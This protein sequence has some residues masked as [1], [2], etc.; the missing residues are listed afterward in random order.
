[1]PPHVLS[2]HVTYGGR[3]RGA[4]EVPAGAASDRLLRSGVSL[5]LGAGVAG[6]RR[7]GLVYLKL[8]V[9]GGG[10][11]THFSTKNQHGQ[12]KPN[13]RIFRTISC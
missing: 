6:W 9:C 11:W 5:C 10:V 12:N 7:L 2:A 8:Q 13:Y 1:M 4:L 3:R